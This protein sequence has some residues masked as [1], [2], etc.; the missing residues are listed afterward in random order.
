MEWDQDPSE[1]SAA[2]PAATHQDRTANRELPASPAK[3]DVPAGPAADDWSVPPAGSQWSLPSP[4]PDWPAPLIGAATPTRPDGWSSPFE[5]TEAEPPRRRRIGWILGGGAIACALVGAVIVVL[6]PFRHSPS[7]T[8]L[9]LGAPSRNAAAGTAHF[10]ADVILKQGGHQQ[11]VMKM[12]G[13]QDPTAKTARITLDAAS[14]TSEIR[15]IDGIEYFSSPLAK[16]PD[17]KTWVKIDPAAVGITPA[18]ATPNDPMAQLALLGGLVGA[19]TVVGTDTIDGTDVT[20]YDV[21]LDL[22]KMVDSLTQGATALGSSNS[23][24]EGLKAL[25]AYTDLQHVPGHVA[26]D[27]QGRARTFSF[28]LHIDSPKG[29]LDETLDM[30]FTD[31]GNA[32]SVATPPDDQVVPFS[33]VPD[34][35]KKMT[36]G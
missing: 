8:T 11:T 27:D 30:S 4:A 16:L 19:P 18:A 35:F 24:L 33:E 5:L 10:T 6:G 28:D 23:L 9:I 34:V 3:T 26:L 12:H 31:F 1:P 7:A 15:M 21:T 14:S 36:G 13:D 29:S 22:T 2:E 20:R 25:S 17:G 32:V